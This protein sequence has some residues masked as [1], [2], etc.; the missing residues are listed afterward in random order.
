MGGK[1]RKKKKKKEKRPP[2]PEQRAEPEHQEQQQHDPKLNDAKEQAKDDLGLSAHVAESRPRRLVSI[3]EAC[4]YARISRTKLYQKL[5]TDVI[6]AYKR[7]G[8]TL[9]DLNTI[10]AM[11]ESLE[12]WK[13][14][15]T[16]GR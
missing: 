11:H 4:M 3:K 7:D 2:E 5:G 15:G 16:K 9:V 6:K 8:A 12:E 10:D 13:S 14:T 1:H